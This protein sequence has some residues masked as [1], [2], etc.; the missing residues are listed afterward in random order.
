MCNSVVST[1]P[2]DGLA[3]LGTR[4]SVVTVM[5]KFRPYRYA[6]SRNDIYN[7]DIRWYIKFSVQLQLGLGKK[8]LKIKSYRPRGNPNIYAV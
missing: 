6:W 2:T 7:P 8:S 1:I 4:T 5:T 3:S